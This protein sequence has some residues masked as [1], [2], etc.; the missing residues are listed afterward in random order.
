MSV[1]YTVLKDGVVVRTGNCHPEDL[2]HQAS[3]GESVQEGSLPFAPVAET[4]SWNYAR[5]LAYPSLE[6]FADAYYWAAHG[7]ET[8]MA[9][10]LEQC[11]AVKAAIKKS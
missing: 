11:S 5:K 10:W 8:R 2:E 3:V 4:H 9:A 1:A 6:A 7:D